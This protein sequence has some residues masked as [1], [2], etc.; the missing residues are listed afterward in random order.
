MRQRNHI[1]PVSGEFHPEFF[2]DGVVESI[3]GEELRQ[4]E[5]ADGNHQAGFEDFQFAIKPGGVVHDFIAGG[6]PVASG[7]LF[8]GKAPAHGSH[9]DAGTELSLI[10]AGRLL[11]PLEERAPRRPGEGPSQLWLLIS[12]RLA[13]EHDSAHDRTTADD[14]LVHGRAA[15]A[16]K[17]LLH[18]P[19]Q[20]LFYSSCLRHA[21]IKPRENDGTKRGNIIP[22]T[23]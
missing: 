1:K 5:L 23:V 22:T 11:K 8:A 14:G 13:N 19:R 20:Q 9:V 2:P 6:N 21:R 18:V 3:D 16:C 15:L 7:G 17:Q 10:Y 12:R 4:S